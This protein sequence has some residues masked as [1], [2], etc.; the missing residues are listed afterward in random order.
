MGAF[1]EFECIIIKERQADGIA[2][3]KARGVY[4]NRERKPSINHDQVTR[5]SKDGMTPT[6]ISRQLNISRMSVHRMLKQS[7]QNN[8]SAY[9][10]TPPAWGCRLWGICINRE[11]YARGK[12]IGEILF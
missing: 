10:H 6:N 3:T 5:L 1:A 4:A 9:S 7:A 12:L 11:I 8:E 2:K